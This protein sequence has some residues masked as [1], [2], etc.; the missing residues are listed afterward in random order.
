MV[1]KFRVSG[2]KFRVVFLPQRLKG[3][4][5]INQRFGLK[6]FSLPFLV[7][8]SLSLCGKKQPETRNLKLE[9]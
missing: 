8:V 2:F 7:F 5:L 1:R 6:D 3:T 4:N 9:N